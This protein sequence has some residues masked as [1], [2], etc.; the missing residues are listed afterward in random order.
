[1][2]DNPFSEEKFPNIQSKPPLVQLEA[3]S[4]CPITCY[5]GEETDP[6]L[7]TTSFQ[8]VVESNKV[9]PQPPFLQA[10]Q[11]QL[12]QPLLIG[13]LLQTLHQL[14]CPSLDTLLDME[15]L[16]HVQRRATKMIRG[17]EHHSY[18]ERLRELGLFSLEKTRLW[19]DLIAAFQYLKGA[20]R[21]DEDRLFSKACCV[22][23]RNNSFKLREGRFRLDLRKN[24]FTRRVVRH[25]NRLPREVVEAP[26]LETFKVS[27]GEAASGV[28]FPVLDSL[29]R[30]A[31]PVSPA[32]VHEDAH[33][34]INVFKYLKGECKEEGAKHFS[35]VPS[36]RTRG[37]GHKLK[38]RRCHLN[39]RKHFFTMRVTKHWHRLPRELVESPSL[40]IF[41][42]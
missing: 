31:H 5:L 22:R 16:D 6:H 19:G 24:F 32:K 28:L 23:T 37:N 4:S 33:D 29:E 20:Y 25:W 7:S 34:L 30:H 42:T 41:K 9:S 39:I 1:M 11:S 3:I 12:P 17:L 8:V 2:L 27:S 13:L 14:R 35:V 10:K 21:K 36:D 15:L 18:E 26:L 38:Q 40:E